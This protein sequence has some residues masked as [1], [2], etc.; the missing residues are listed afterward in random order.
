M[1]VWIRFLCFAVIVWLKTLGPGPKRHDPKPHKALTTHNTHHNT[2]H[3][4][5]VGKVQSCGHPPRS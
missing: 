1:G 5:I 2:H 3:N 4:A